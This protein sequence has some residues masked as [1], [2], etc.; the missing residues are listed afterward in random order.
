MHAP[1]TSVT[2]PHALLEQHRRDIEALDRRI[3]HLVCERLEL[4]RQVGELKGDLSVPLRNFKV[5]AQV[6][7]RFEDASSLLGLD[8]GLGRDLARFLIEKAVEEQAT[9]RDAVYAGDALDTVVIGGKGGMGRWICR[10][11]AGQGHRVR[12]IDPSDGETAFDEAQSLS[13]AADADLIMVAVPMSLCPGILDEL[14]AVG[15][16]G[17][18]AEMCSL[19]GHLGPTIARLRSAGVRVISFHP[20]F[21][22]DVRMLEGRT[23]AF[24]S[25]APREDL[26][27]V[28]GLFADTS[29]RLVE[30]DPME[31]DRRMGLVLGLTHL[32][33]LVFARA[34]VLSEVGA[35]ELAEVA[36]VTFGRQLETTR[37][38]AS[39]N[40]SLYYEIQALNGLT[41]ETGRWLR[42]ALDDWLE[43]IEEPGD[44]RFAELMTTCRATLDDASGRNDG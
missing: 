30:M 12:V 19:K 11:L 34:L 24:C 28:E 39:E 18:V 44:D 17:V 31:H 27:V 37:E 32:A 3:L 38:V 15:P 7:R 36:G 2:D 8:V 21:G 25:D 14:A 26:E 29:A 42:E 43:A 33:N 5:E 6:Y 9:L 35:D 1:Q 22:P 40:P 41:P 16:R 10:L 4:A 20:M 13:D 23:V